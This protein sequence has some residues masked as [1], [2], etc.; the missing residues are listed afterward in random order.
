MSPNQ[1]PQLT[2][3]D[4]PN[5]PYLLHE[6]TQI[7]PH[8]RKP[9]NVRPL[10]QRS[11]TISAFVHYLSVRP[12]PS[13]PIP[14]SGHHKR[15]HHPTCNLPQSFPSTSPFLININ[16][17][18]RLHFIRLRLLHPNTFISN[19]DSRSRVLHSTIHPLPS[20]TIISIHIRPLHPQSPSLARLS[21][22]RHPSFCIRTI[23]P[24]SPFIEMHSSTW[25]ATSL[26]KKRVSQSDAEDTQ[27]P[28]E[29][30]TRAPSCCLLPQ[31]SVRTS[32][33]C[34]APSF[35]PFTA[36]DSTI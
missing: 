20:T 19:H 25:S 22:N 31:S 30:C 9:A 5:P 33:H 24:L 12:L 7:T 29:S 13:S 15:S 32:P 26:L 23:H 14:A 10:S 36:P 11:S 28:R 4:P 21:L 8:Q 34:S 17:S 1:T 27:R 3:P 16:S 2:S 6:V 35:L 18:C